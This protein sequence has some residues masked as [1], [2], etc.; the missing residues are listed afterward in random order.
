MSSTRSVPARGVGE[1]CS[2]RRGKAAAQGFA[3]ALP[4]AGKNKWLQHPVN[5]VTLTLEQTSS[6]SS[7]WP[8][9]VH[10]S[11]VFVISINSLKSNMIKHNTKLE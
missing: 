4:P 7:V 8:E 5:S 6:S 9:L 3:A 10:S 11:L 2:G 1:P